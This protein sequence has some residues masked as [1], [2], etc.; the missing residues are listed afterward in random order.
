M[1]NDEKKM[2]NNSGKYPVTG[3]R[4]IDLYHMYKSGDL[5]VLNQH[6]RPF[7]FFPAMCSRMI[8]SVLISRMQG[9]IMLEKD[10]DVTRVLDGVYRLLTFFN[11]IDN[12][13]HDG[14]EF[15]FVTNN[16][17]LKELNGKTFSEFPAEMQEKIK[18]YE[19]PVLYTKRNKSRDEML[20][21][22][23]SRINVL[24]DR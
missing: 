2:E 3:V 9:L 15:R 6:N 1:Y 5:E 13:I 14:S 17:K 19:L 10:Y 12:E 20:I 23:Q 4:V 22:L 16:E 18:R 11:F 8:E 21:E 7:V 24:R